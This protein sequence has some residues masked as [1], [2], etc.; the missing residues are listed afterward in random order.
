MENVKFYEKLDEID[1]YFLDVKKYKPLSKKEEFDLA[2]KI[3]QGDEEALQKLVNANLRF[4][5]TI[6]KQYRNN[7]VCFSD[8]ISE[9][10]IGLMRAASK[11]DRNRGVKFI[12]YAV[13]WIRSSI[14]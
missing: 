6:A 3:Q 11:F 7:G 13:W 8:L 10:N 9:G 5:V 12:S 2:D 14:N 4:V 1:K